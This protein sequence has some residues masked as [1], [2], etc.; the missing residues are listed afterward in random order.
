MTRTSRISFVI[1]A[2]PGSGSGAGAGIQDT[3]HPV[4]AKVAQFR[5]TLTKAASSCLTSWCSSAYT[6]YKASLKAIP[7]RGHYE[8]AVSGPH[9]SFRE[10][11][12]C[13]LVPI[14]G[15]SLLGMTGL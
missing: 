10:M 7:N 1:P 9:F 12:F 14:S 6:R 4:T 11:G 3:C 13:A 5:I 8:R 2:N 15:K